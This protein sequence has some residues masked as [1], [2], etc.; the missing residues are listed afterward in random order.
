M[1]RRQ[2]RPTTRA[3]AT[4]A[5][6]A[7]F[8]AAIIT[9][10][11]SLLAGGSLVAI[12]VLWHDWWLP[13]REAEAELMDDAWTPGFAGWRVLERCSIDD[14]GRTRVERCLLT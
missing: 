2:I 13:A 14:A 3:A 8:A 1:T 9:D 10:P 6:F 12:L 5:L 4:G 7:V 11:F